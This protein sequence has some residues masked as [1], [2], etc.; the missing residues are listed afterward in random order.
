MAFT[1]EAQSTTDYDAY[2]KSVTGLPLESVHLMGLG[3]VGEDNIV[4]SLVGNLPM[5]R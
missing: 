5:L 3:V 4:N 1:R 2:E